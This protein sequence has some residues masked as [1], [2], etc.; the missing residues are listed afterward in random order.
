MKVGIAQVD[1]MKYMGTIFPNTALMQIT[2]YHERLGDQVEWYKGRLFDAEYGAVYA[3]KVF[4]FSKMPDL[5]PDA[6]I[7]GTGVDFE[8]NLPPA[9]Q[10][11]DYSYSLYPNVN[12]HVGFAMKG[13]RMK[14]DFCCVPKKEGRAHFNAHVH[15]LLTNPNG[16]NRLM[17]LDNDFFGVAE[18]REQLQ[19]IIEAKLKVCFVQGMNIRIITAEQAA[20][21][22][23]VNY[24]NS[25]FNQKYLSFAWDVFRDGKHILKGIKICNDAGIPTKHM[26]FFVLIG[27]DSTHE[28]NLER[29]MQLRK[30]GAMP[31][32]MPYNK[33]D[34]YQKAFCRWV[35]NRAVFKSCSWEDYKY[36]P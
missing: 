17:L 23:Q 34:P 7:G 2:R 30:L 3:S 36:K 32:A 16:G 15:S 22:S 29:V 35:N 11:M 1:D 25:R 6:I 33:N 24:T 19:Y 21:L 10:H 5:P 8:N 13:C 12:F 9:I 31:F 27:F 26:Q 18:W 14:C 20:L 4:S 28:Q